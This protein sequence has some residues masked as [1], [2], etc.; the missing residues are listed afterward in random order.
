MYVCKKS[1]VFQTR[2]KVIGDIF[3]LNAYHFRSAAKEI[4][5][6][7][8]IKIISLCLNAGNFLHLN[9]IKR[10]KQDK[11]YLFSKALKEVNGTK[12]HHQR[13]Y[14]SIKEIC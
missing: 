3:R 2:Q 6:A 5:R 1:A 10:I 14:L 11:N 12:Q 13:T 8:T 4:L 9:R 7:I